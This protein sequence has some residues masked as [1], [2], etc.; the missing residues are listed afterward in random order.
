MEE[1]ILKSTKKLLGIH[2]DD[3][4]FDLDVLILINSAFSTLNEL[5]VK[6]DTVITVEDDTKTWSELGLSEAALA[7]VKVYVY[8]K[9]RLTFDPPPTSFAIAAVEKIIEE[10]TWRI[11]EFHDDTVATTYPP[12]PI[13]EVL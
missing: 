9:V 8:L 2:E 13:E 5:G 11:A 4:A 7:L 12:D 1:S 6:K 10:H 3:S